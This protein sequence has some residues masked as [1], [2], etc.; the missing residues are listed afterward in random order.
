MQSTTATT[1]NT[2]NIPARELRSGST[3]V[4]TKRG[5]VMIRVTHVT[6]CADGSLRVFT[7]HGDQRLTGSIRVRVLH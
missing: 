2:V 5:G 1:R 4:D 6:I 3:I 7:D